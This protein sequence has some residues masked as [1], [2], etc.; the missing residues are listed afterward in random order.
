MDNVRGS[1]DACVAAYL[2]YSVPAPLTGVITSRS[3]FT[4]GFAPWELMNPVVGQLHVHRLGVCLPTR[5]QWML[6]I[7]S[8]S[9]AGTLRK[10]AHLTLCSTVIG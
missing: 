2:G 4:V 1:S 6:T 5:N 8:P 7:F 10:F 9:D 3:S